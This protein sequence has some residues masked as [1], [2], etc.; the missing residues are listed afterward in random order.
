M[1]EVKIKVLNE[2][3]I[4][5]K[6][7]EQDAGFDLRAY[8]DYDIE[9]GLT[10][11]I[12]TGCAIELPVEDEWIWEAQVRP[13]SGMSVKT[14]MRICNAPGTVDANFRDN[15][16]VIMENTGDTLYH[17]SQG[18]KIAQL[19]ITKMPKVKLVVADELTDTDRGKN[20]FGSTGK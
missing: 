11:I 14:K 2:N 12:N 1:N 7:H 10:K 9:P 20:G 19:V 16:G 15:I 6:A 8:E 5:I 3:C 18:D 13:R 17:I 4:P